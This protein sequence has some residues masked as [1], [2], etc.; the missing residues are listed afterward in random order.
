M[1]NV[2]DFYKKSLEGK[3]LEIPSKK[4]W[5][6]IK[7][8]SD[9]RNHD[10]IALSEG[11]KK[12]S[13]N[14]MFERW[15]QTARA[16]T[17]LGITQANNSRVLALM[18]NVATTCDINYG[19]NM[20]GAVADYID[21][22]TKIDLVKKYIEQEKITDIFVLDL[23]MEQTGMSKNIEELKKEY[24]IRNIIVHHDNFLTSLMP[25]PIRTFSLVKDFMNKHSKQILRFSDVVEDSRYTQISY[26]SE[27][28]LDLS[29]ITHTSGTTT[30][31]GKPIPLTDRNRNALTRNYEL[32]NF[33]YKPGMTMMHFIPYFAGYGVVNTAHFSLTQGFELQ[34]VPLFTPNDFG[35]YLDQLKSNIVF[36]TPSCWLNLINDKRFANIDLSY[37]LYASSGGG[38]L[39]IKNEE[40]I[41]SFLRKHGATCDITKGYG[42]SETCGCC[43]YTMDG[44][45]QLGSLGVRHPL[46]DIILRNPITGEIYPSSYVGQGEALVHSETTTSGI[47][48]GRVIVPMEIIDGKKYYPTKDILDR[49]EDGHYEYVERVDRMFPRYD[50]YNVY[51][52]HIENLIQSFKEINECVIVPSF[53]PEKNGMVPKAYISLNDTADI[54][55]KSKYIENFLVN[56]FLKHKEDAPYKANY[57]DI[58]RSFVFVDKIPRNTMDKHDY[59]LLKQ[60][61]QGEEYQVFVEEDNMGVSS[62]SVRKK[63]IETKKS[64]IKK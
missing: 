34:Q 44:Y 3:D 51:P 10:Y 39:S 32:G 2:E 42:L 59:H 15:N 52:L 25:F 7:D 58:P 53:D 49:K 54:E 5:K 57:R 37:L 1:I 35:V 22:T 30:G 33:N 46:V 18:P 50:G 9:A 31:V 61:I 43:I 62:L 17:S 11:A 13:Y 14:E 64:F 8:K 21:P 47:L 19:L 48:D 29:L 41:N 20:T 55:D 56:S 45:N 63:D 24:G 26:G 28:D 60:G 16:F 12:I 27:S 6:L 36:A 38:P 40:K 4:S 23:L